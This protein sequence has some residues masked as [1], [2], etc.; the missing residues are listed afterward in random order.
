MATLSQLPS[1]QID[2]YVMDFRAT[3]STLSSALAMF[4]FKAMNAPTSVERNEAAAAAIETRRD[5][6]LA[7]MQFAATTRGNASVIP[8]TSEQVQQAVQR[9]TELAKVNALNAQVSSFLEAAQ[10]ASAAFTGLHPAG[11]GPADAN[12][13]LVQNALAALMAV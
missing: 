7:E 6:D 3:V 11:P 8:P 12:S 4:H 1:P 2:A 13:P 10:L 5:L 9:A